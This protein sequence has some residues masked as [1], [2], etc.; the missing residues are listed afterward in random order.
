[1]SEQTVPITPRWEFRTFGE[2]FGAAE[3]VL[4]GLPAGEPEES[5]ELYLLSD[6][7]DNVKVRGGV[8]DIKVLRQADR[9]GLERWEPVMKAGFPLERAAV[10]RLFEALRVPVPVLAREAYS[11]DEL[12]VDVVEA[13]PAIRVVPVH[14]RRVRY[15]VGGCMS[16]LS[17]IGAGGRR[18]RTLAVEAEDPAAVSAAV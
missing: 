18:T 11:L 6:D 16:E 10:T 14:K 8:L 4:E 9:H 5:E 15:T 17:D 3:E 2:S 13:S 1:M 7:G 12:L